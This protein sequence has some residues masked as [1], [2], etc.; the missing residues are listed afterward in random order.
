MTWLGRH[1]AVV[2]IG[3][4]VGVTAVL[5]VLAGTGDTGTSAPLDPANPGPDGARA[6]AQVLGD[7][8]VDVTVARGADELEDLELGRDVTVLVTSA[9]NLGQSTVR[10][11]RDHLGGAR[12]VVVDPP[13]LVVG[14]IDGSVESSG[15]SGA[16]R[17]EADCSDGLLR[18]LSL[19]VDQATGFSG[20]TTR[21]FPIDGSWVYT[22]TADGVVLLGAGQILTNDQVTRADNAAA[23]LRLLGQSSS[24]VWYVPDLSDQTAGDSVSLRSLLPPWILPGL[25]LG[26]VTLVVVVIWRGRRLG[27]LVTEPLPVVV[28]AIE[29]TR[30]RGQLYRRA[31][32]RGHASGSLR[33]ATSRRLASRLHLPRSTSV[34]ADLLAMDVARITSRPVREV[35]DLLGEHTQPPASDQDLVR[36]AR[37]LAE[38]EEQ[39]ENRT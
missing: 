18:D 35:H 32:D 30:G 38:L 29:S 24:L 8:G 25:W 1:R 36:L 12:L 14:E 16:G 37:Q 22:E 31:N 27:P 4:V 5:A 7:E 3:L 21:C 15:L 2:V 9:G 33:R 39:V 19:Q 11:L 26:F 20:G 6:V 17:M 13:P 10:R 23:A 34:D 28:R